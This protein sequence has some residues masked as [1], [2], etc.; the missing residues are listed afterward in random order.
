M[1]SSG[2]FVDLTKENSFVYKKKK[3]LCN[4]L[5]KKVLHTCIK[6]KKK[7]NS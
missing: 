3:I 7:G 6:I 4:S 2:S 1:I 5:T